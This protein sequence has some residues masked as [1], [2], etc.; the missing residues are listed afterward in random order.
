MVK[1]FASRRPFDY[2]RDIDI[3]RSPAEAQELIK[4]IYYEVLKSP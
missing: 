3:E 2:V 4:K 1:H